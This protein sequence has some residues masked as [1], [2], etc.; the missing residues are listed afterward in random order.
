M[1]Y[2]LAFHPKAMEEWVST[3]RSVQI[4]L[5]KKL[6]ERLHNPHVPA[7]RLSGH[8]NR[9]KIKLLKAGYRVVYE[10]NDACLVVLVLA[11]GRRDRA[12]VYE[13]AR[14]RRSS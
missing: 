10:V 12:E 14:T 1:T 11:V 13:L 4:L 2:E 7:A 9:Y 3:D 8:T 6:A 5:K